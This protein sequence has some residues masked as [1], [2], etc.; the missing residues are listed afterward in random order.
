MIP[1]YALKH[2]YQLFGT[3]RYGQYLTHAYNRITPAVAA[4][5]S[6]FVLIGAHRHGMAVGSMS[7]GKWPYREYGAC[8]SVHNL[9]LQRK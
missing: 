9:V 7:E 4:I 1:N 2:T 5:D 6:C 8:A 3:P